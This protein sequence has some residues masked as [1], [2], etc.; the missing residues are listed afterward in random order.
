AAM[1]ALTKA[2]AA[3]GMATGVRVNAINPGPVRTDRLAGMIKRIAAEQDIELEQ[4]EV[5]LQRSLGVTRFGEPEDIAALALFVVS[6]R[7]KLL[8]GALLDSDGGLTKSI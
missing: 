7:G 8:Q 6:P 3:R 2:L 1:L 4:A 5:R